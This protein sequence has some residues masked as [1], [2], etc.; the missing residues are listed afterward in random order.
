LTTG[1]HYRRYMKQCAN[2]LF[3]VAGRL[4]RLKINIFG[5]IYES[6]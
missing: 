6:E 4:G 1:E 3:D 2:F 5:G